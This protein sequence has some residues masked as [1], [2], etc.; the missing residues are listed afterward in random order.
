M[1]IK[2]VVVGPI[3]TNCYIVEDEGELLVIDPGAAPER[4]MEEVGEQPV[5][6]IVLTHG[7]WDHMDGLTG[8]AEATGAPIAAGAGDALDIEQPTGRMA[9]MLHDY[10]HPTV[11]RRLGDG[12]EVSVGSV[13]FKVIETPGHTPGSICLYCAEEGVM[14]SGDTVF[15]HGRF[16]RT[17]FET[18]SP[19]DM[20]ESLS[21]LSDIVDDETKIYPGHED[22]TTMKV[23]RALNPYMH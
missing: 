10:G 12:D 6:Y 9:T 18:G 7:H 3:E 5:A 4:I 21:K 11:D 17:D 16:G 23:E 13:T 20:V 1:E 19:E 8:V 2:T 14:F 15:A 22:A